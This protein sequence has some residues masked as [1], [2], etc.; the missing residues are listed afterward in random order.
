M[1]TERRQSSPSHQRNAPA[2]GSRSTK[3][4]GGKSPNEG[5]GSRSAARDY[6]QRTQ[7][8]IHEGRVGQSAEEA[9]RA[10]ESDE[11]DKLEEAER[12]GRGHRRT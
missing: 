12:V 4:E 3:P 11:R 6:N 1:A 7:R 9:K 10:V 8:F 2:S 5:E